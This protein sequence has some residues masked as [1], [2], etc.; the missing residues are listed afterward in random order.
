MTFFN[1]WTGIDALNM[2]SNRLLTKM[3]DGSSSL[4]SANFGTI[5]F[6]FANFFGAVLAYF[7]VKNFGRVQVLL[8]SHLAMGIVQFTLAFCI[9]QD[10]NLVAVLLILVFI[11]FFQISEGPILWIY[12]AEVCHDSAFGIVVL[13]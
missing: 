8:W 4:I 7:S 6:G 3:N 12:S 1:Q 11:I 10:Q 5:L 2:F 13:G 9:M